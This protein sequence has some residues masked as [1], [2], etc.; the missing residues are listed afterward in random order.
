MLVTTAISSARWWQG[1]SDRET[2][3]NV[4]SEFVSLLYLLEEE[5]YSSNSKKEDNSCA[6]KETRIGL[7]QDPMRTASAEGS[8][9]LLLRGASLAGPW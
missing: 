1:A 9:S 2:K 6:E 5:W 8:I 4:D 7:W 3:V